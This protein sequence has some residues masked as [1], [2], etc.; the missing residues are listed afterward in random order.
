MSAVRSI[1]GRFAGLV[2]RCLALHRQTAGTCGGRMYR[3]I[4]CAQHRKA[5]RLA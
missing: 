4:R 2:L 1:P 5:S 3:N